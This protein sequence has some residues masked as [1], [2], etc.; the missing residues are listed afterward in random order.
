[1]NV[2]LAMVAAVNSARIKRGPSYVNV[3]PDTNL[4]LMERIVLV[5]FN[6][7]GQEI[8]SY[9]LVTHFS[10]LM[11]TDIAYVQCNVFC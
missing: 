7:C 8:L 11:F 9:A 3:M 5:R 10:H 1:M 2:R 6:C 4:A